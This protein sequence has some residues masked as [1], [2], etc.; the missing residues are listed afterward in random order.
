M[1]VGFYHHFGAVFEDDGSVLVP[2][3]FGM[4]VNELA[5]Q[6]GHVTLF[7][8]PTTGSGIEDFALRQPPVHP[9]EL[10]PLRSFPART[11]RPAPDVRR[12]RRHLDGLDVMVI[13]GPSA[14]LPSLVR[15]SAPVPVVLYLT[16]DYATS[17]PPRWMPS[18][19]RALI[20][21][22]KSV[23]AMQ[24]RRATRTASVFANSA[25]LARSL[26]RDGAEVREVP[27]SVLTADAIGNDPAQ[28]SARDITRAGRRIRLLY[29]GR[30]VE[31]KG[32]REAIESVDRLSVGGLDVELD[33]VGWE[34]DSRFA[35]ELRDDVGE[36][37]LEDRV[38]FRGYIPNGPALRE[39]YR[40]ADVFVLPSHHEGLPLAL[41]EAMAAGLPVVATRVGGIPDVVADAQSA[42]LVEPR[43][44]GAIAD[45]VSRLAL[46]AGL[47]SRFAA[48]GWRIA[49]ELT[50]ERSCSLLC[51]GLEAIL[52]RRDDRS[53]RA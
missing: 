26:R 37:G 8:H 27:W 28:S 38:R 6:C 47:R 39:V 50:L 25:A 24:Q 31:E 17:T 53:A 29:V 10:G 3:Y 1:N 9:V 5:V 16:G 32:L 19:R 15:A 22:W 4:F 2:A 36:R 23:Y 33:L 43:S 21:V 44:A 34:D 13:L 46:D 48:G 12:F 11:L 20:H 30:I 41:I 42:L 51:E 7:A 52:A 49:R 35:A 18:W 40:S 14:L 45:A